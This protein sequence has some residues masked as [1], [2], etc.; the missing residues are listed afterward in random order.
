MGN[1]HYAAAFSEAVLPVLSSF[2]PDLILVACGF[3][4]VEGDL[5]GDNVISPHMYYIMTRSL[6]ETCGSDIPLV[7]VLEG[8]YNLDVISKCFE[9]TALALLDEP[10]C[11]ELLPPED[12]FK[13]EEVSADSFAFSFPFSA[14]TTEYRNKLNKKMFLDDQQ[15]TLQRYWRHEDLA[16]Y[17][18]KH[19]ADKT[20][21]CALT[22]IRKSVRALVRKGGFRGRLPLASEENKGEGSSFLLPAITKPIVPMCNRPVQGQYDP[23][24]KMARLAAIEENQE[25]AHV[26]PIKKRKLR[27]TQSFDS[28]LMYEHY[29]Y[30][31]SDVESLVSCTMPC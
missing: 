29:Y 8:G 13:E 17:Q 1:T 30:S 15:L 20:T 19:A 11:D 12:R 9:A 21:T 3:D 31:N 4:A 23:Q 14:D 22:S 2:N 25:D 10:L 5:L 16:L 26:L 24:E 6:L 18:D 27:R 28:T 7:M